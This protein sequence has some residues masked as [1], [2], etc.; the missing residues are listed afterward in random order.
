[1]QLGGLPGTQS[2]ST[3]E[4]APRIR[5][6]HFRPPGTRH[7]VVGNRAAHLGRPRSRRWHRGRCILARQWQGSLHACRV[8]GARREWCVSACPCCVCVFSESARL[9]F[10]D[11][12]PLFCGLHLKLLNA[13]ACGLVHG[14]WW[15][16]STQRPTVQ[17]NVGPPVGGS[18][19]ARGYEGI[20]SVSAVSKGAGMLNSTSP[21]TLVFPVEDLGGL[22]HQGKALHG[23]LE[24]QPISSKSAAAR[25]GMR[26]ALLACRV[27][28]ELVSPS[29]SNKLV[30]DL[31]GRLRRA[32][33]AR[34]A[35]AACSGS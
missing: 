27:P 17:L 10:P 18:H 35:A 2:R 19:R 20:P 7:A 29:W 1:M 33:T 4:A 6:L 23:T 34:R 26:C 14:L 30:E 5:I 21:T 15:A 8:I 25:R 13:K 28:V 9:V 22:C 31:A 12:C 3:P 11:V 16:T 24:Q 32:S